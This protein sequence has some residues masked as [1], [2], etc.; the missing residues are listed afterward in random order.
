MEK[1]IKT[2]FCDTSYIRKKGL[3]CNIYDEIGKHYLEKY[4]H[5]YITVEEFQILMDDLGYTRNRQG[6]YRLRLRKEFLNT[7]AK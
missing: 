3:N 1:A 6:R 2:I 5:T 7:L 4:L